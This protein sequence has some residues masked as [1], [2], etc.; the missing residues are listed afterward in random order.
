LDR[1]GFPF[2][3]DDPAPDAEQRDSPVQRGLLDY[4]R[5]HGY[6]LTPGNGITIVSL[7]ATV[8]RWTLL[9]T[10]WSGCRHSCCSS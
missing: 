1:D 4:L 5:R 7:F 10:S 3:A 2:G 8:L 6:Y 9:R